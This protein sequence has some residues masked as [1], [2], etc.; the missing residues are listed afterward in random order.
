MHRPTHQKFSHVEDKSYLQVQLV[1]P[2]MLWGLGVPAL[3]S[4]P[5][6]MLDTTCARSSAGSRN[7]ELC[8]SIP[9]QA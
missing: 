4:R 8:N 9:C 1:G 6:S 5:Q 3:L 7:L 2:Q